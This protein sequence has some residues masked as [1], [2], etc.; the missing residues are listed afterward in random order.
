MPIY[1][2][3]CKKHGKTEM[4]LNVPTS[5]EC[6]TCKS[7]M[8][9]DYTTEHAGLPP[10]KSYVTN[11]FTPRMVEINSKEDQRKWEKKTGYV[12]VS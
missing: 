12:R 2:F 5:Q 1:V 6:P 10:F 9:R 3:K 8:D 7:V 4:F 11:A